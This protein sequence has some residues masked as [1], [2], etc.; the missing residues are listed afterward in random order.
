MIKL[1]RILLEKDLKSV[2]DDD[3]KMDVPVE[4]T[5]TIIKGLGGHDPWEYYFHD[6]DG[7][8]K[9]KR[10]TASKF[11]DMKT[12]LI[13]LYGEE[14]G[15]TKYKNA[16]DLLNSYLEN[17]NKAER[18]NKQ[19]EDVVIPDN[20]VEVPEIHIDYDTQ[21]VKEKLIDANGK[22]NKFVDVLGKSDDGKYLK[23]R[24][25]N[26]GILRREIEVYVEADSFDMLD[27]GKTAEYN[28]KEGKTY[29]IYKIK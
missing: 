2:N 8:W 11:L 18:D 7:M 25:R 17:R 20:Q 16:V 4:K 19:I 22:R 12:K 1:K 5:G 14:T 28:G 24:L 29:N 15:N 9:T 3:I 21:K 6:A 13:R 26:R 10:N 27:D 23:V